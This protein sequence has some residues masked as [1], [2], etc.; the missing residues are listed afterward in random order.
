MSPIRARA[1][2]VMLM[3]AVLAISVGWSAAPARSDGDPASDVLVADSV[4]YPYSSTV[5]ASL[6]RTLNGE[7]AA[8]SRAHFPVKVALIPA[9]FDLGAIPSLFGKPQTYAS[10]L[11]QE[12]SFLDVTTR[13]LVVMPNGY[14]V[15]NLGP[16]ASHVVASLNKPAGARGDDLAQAAIVALP[17]LAAAA[18]HPIGPAAA[19]PNAAVSNSGGSNS[20]GGSSMLKVGVLA[21]VA[22][23]IAGTLFAFRRGR[24]ARR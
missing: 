13:L 22:I 15:R 18:G 19:A 8:A 11:G 17:K 21:L 3:L 14:G 16:G 20:G 23:V 24:A 7:A 1:H 4:F 9:P 12:I 5:S 6:Q 2:A 10:F